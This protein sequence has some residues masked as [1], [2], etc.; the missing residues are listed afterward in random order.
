M[1]IIYIG[2]GAAA[3]IAVSYYFQNKRIL[4]VDFKNSNEKDFLI[5][6]NKKCKDE[7][8]EVKNQLAI[9]KGN[10]KKGRE[11][12]D[13]AIDNREDREFEVAKLKKNNSDL[14]QEIEKLKADLYEYEMLY[15]ARKE[16]VSELKKQLGKN[17]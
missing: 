11:E 1:S 8:E 12:M 7:L 9:T 16:E 10:L 14:A 13:S 17:G 3:G 15:N 2:M 6:Q 5:S 4:A